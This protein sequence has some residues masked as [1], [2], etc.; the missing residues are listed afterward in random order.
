MEIPQ[1]TVIHPTDPLLLQDLPSKEA[2]ELEYRPPSAM[3]L[4]MTQWEIVSALL[5]PCLIANVAAWLLYWVVAPSFTR[6]FF[7]TLPSGLLA[8]LVWVTIQVV[9]RARKA[10]SKRRFPRELA[11]PTALTLAI[12]GRHCFGT[13]AQ[14]VG[15]AGLFVAG[16]PLVLWLLD[17]IQWHGIYWFSSDLEPNIRRESR[18]NAVDDSLTKSRL[19][20]DRSTRL[21]V[22]A[23]ALGTLPCVLLWNRVMDSITWS[24]TTILIPIVVLAVLQVLFASPERNAVD[25]AQNLVASWF[26]Y[27]RNKSLAPFMFQS[28][29]G[30]HPD[31]VTKTLVVGGA[32]SCLLG[33]ALS[34]TVF[35]AGRT[36]LTADEF[37]E[38]SVLIALLDFLIAAPTGAM[39]VAQ[40]IW[41]S[42]SFVP[43]T[44]ERERNG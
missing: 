10:I 19:Q 8:M 26:K 3:Q 6:S 18:R 24:W 44:L 21:W 1:R 29:A 31:R 22:C 11:F 30:S 38:A 14:L 34:N 42:V 25:R 32:F 17:D 27:G 33:F 36:E 2:C 13:D 23:I 37:W 9:R 39:L 12:C 5:L 4:R 28:P 15:L 43:Q 35:V 7:I 16:I 20:E 40:A 41:L